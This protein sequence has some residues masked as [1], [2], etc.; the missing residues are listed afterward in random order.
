MS[1]PVPCREQIVA[2][3]LTRL[4]AISG[5]VAE[6]ERRDPLTAEDLESSSRLILFEGA[7]SDATL[8]T[9]EDG[10]EFSLTVQGTVK[11]NGPASSTALN[12]LRAK[13]L[14]ALC[15]PGD[16]TLGGLAR[17]VEISDTGDE[18]V[19]GIATDEFKGFVLEATVQYATA[20]GDPFTFADA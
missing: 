3:A 15:P 17:H 8:Y 20:E 13:V 11:G 16:C 10:F 14:T 19:A 12:L 7:D 4:Q 9:M 6:R 2:A 5:A 1:D 18:L